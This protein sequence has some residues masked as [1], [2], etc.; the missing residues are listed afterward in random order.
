MIRYQP[1]DLRTRSADF[2]LL[3]SAFCHPLFA[4]WCLLTA[5]SQLQKSLRH[6]ARGIIF[7]GPLLPLRRNTFD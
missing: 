5:F 4:I 7:E 1:S 6:F 3:T 2:W